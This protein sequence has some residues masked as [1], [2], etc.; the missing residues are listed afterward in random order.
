[1][2]TS[3]I[4]TGMTSQHLTEEAGLRWQMGDATAAERAHVAQCAVCQ[5][6]T[7]PLAESLQL[8]ST[9]AQQW[10][11]AKAATTPRKH[12]GQ[13]VR[14]GWRVIAAVCALLLLTI[15]IG[16]VRWQSRQAA[17]Q[18][19]AQQQVQQQMAQD[20]ALL[21]AVDQDVS[22]VVPDALT[23]LAGSSNSNNGNRQ[24]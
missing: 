14:L 4:E 5:S 20:D 8:F 1:M 11:A 23:P 22:Q 17:L 12:V 16:A 6:Q 10:G 9:A 19:A 21:E 24:Q 3:Q 15:S 2:S 13:A 18:V 7:Y